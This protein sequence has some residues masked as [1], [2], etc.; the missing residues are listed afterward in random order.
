MK[1]ERMEVPYSTGREV[2]LTT[3]PAGSCDTHCHIFDPV[4]YPYKPDD[5]RN[6]PPATVGCYRLLMRRLGIDRCVVV[7]P[8]AYGVDNRC[9]LHAL[10]CFGDAARGI[11][12]IDEKTTDQELAWMNEQGIRGIRF[13]VVSGSR[14]SLEHMAE[15]AERIKKYQWHILLWLP[16]DILVD[17]H[18]WLWKLPCQVVF[19]HRG[20]IPAE[21]GVQ[22]KA[23]EIISDLMKDDRAYV[24]L[25]ALYHD[26]KD[27]VYRDT[28][29]LSLKYIEQEENH[30]LWGTDWPHHSEVINRRILPDDAKMLDALVNAIQDKTKIQKLFVDNPQKLYRF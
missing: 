16:A 15:L 21:I 10:K 12:V 9:T 17:I 14:G 3:L 22:H 30:V 4:H 27:P 28:I 20:H 7:T 1:K 26:S 19:D 18:K 13:N 6:Q 25:S 23:F 8:S 2:P 24:K 11:A 29:D 5:T